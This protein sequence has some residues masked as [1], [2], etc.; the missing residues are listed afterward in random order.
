MDTRRI[1]FL[2]YFDPVF[3]NL[4]TIYENNKKQKY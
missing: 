2:K 4:E 1:D 3:I